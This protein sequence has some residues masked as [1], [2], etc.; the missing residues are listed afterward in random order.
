VWVHNA[1]KLNCKM[2]HNVWEI[3]DKK[4]SSAEVKLQSP[5]NQLRNQDQIPDD[6]ITV[7][8]F[9]SYPETVCC[10]GRRNTHYS[11]HFR[12]HRF[13]KVT[14]II[15]WTTAATKWA[16]ALRPVDWHP[17]PLPLLTTCCFVVAKW[18]M[19]D[20]HPNKCSWRISTRKVDAFENQR[21]LA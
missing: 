9:V 11:Y 15:N 14:G 7:R 1:E 6:Y 12:T 4:R 3:P 20:T 2:H 5:T 18:H 13:G 16:Y 17:E 10:S 19:W 21:I 8:S